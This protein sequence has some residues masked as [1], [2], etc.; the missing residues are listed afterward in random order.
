MAG[1]RQGQLRAGKLT[2][3]GRARDSGNDVPLACC[4]VLTALK[5]DDSA[6]GCRVRAARN[7]NNISPMDC[8]F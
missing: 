8:K 4:P 7:N 3:G 1:Q 6:G 2:V 5:G